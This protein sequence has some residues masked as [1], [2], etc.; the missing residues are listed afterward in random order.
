MKIGVMLRGVD[1]RGGTGIYAQNLVPK[2]LELGPEHEWILIYR[3]E[4][5]LG[6]FAIPGR[7][8]EV[9]LHARGSILWDQQ[10]IPR[11]AAR[12][13]LDL[14]FNTKFTLPLLGK[15]PAVMAL[16]GASWY[17]IPECYPWWDVRYIKMTMP[18][19]CR[20]A[21]H[22]VS[23]S[24]C[25]TKDYVEIIGVPPEKITTVHLAAAPHFHKVT[26]EATLVTVRRKYKLADEFILSVVAHDPRKNVRRLLEAFA[27][28]RRRRP[29]K[30]VLI[31]RDCERFKTEMGEVIAGVEADISFLGWVEQSDLPALYSLASV[32][33]FPSLYEEFGIPNCEAMAC[34]TPIVSSNTGAP[35]EVVGDAGMQTDPLDVKKM[36]D[37]LESVLEDD[38]LR[39][40]LSRQGVERSRRFSW[41][42]TARVTLRTLENTALS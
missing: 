3:S 29:C 39:A 6:R 23:N 10:A 14:L 12:E 9:V 7:G 21:A 13:R 25:T 41:D 27:E 42:R 22:L 20:R 18:L 19:Y 37:A 31:G 5:Q 16:H 24:H 26:D 35:P 32:F 30:L 38:N 1:K 8:R 17:V 4:D 33:F 2:L 40:E 36:A 28:T 15:T 11:F 34:G